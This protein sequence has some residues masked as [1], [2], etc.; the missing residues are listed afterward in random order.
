ML[1]LQPFSQFYVLFGTG[2]SQYTCGL[3]PSN[4]DLASTADGLFEQN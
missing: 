2:S 4:R 3:S 1:H